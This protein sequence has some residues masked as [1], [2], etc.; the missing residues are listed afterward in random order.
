MSCDSGKDLPPYHL[1]HGSVIPSI[2]ADGKI[3]TTNG[4]NFSEDG[5]MLYTSKTIAKNS[6]S[7]TPFA[8]IFTSE[9]NDGIWRE[10]QQILFPI[11]A[12]HPVL[13]HDQKKLYFNSRSHPDTLD[14]FIKH[15][16]WVSERLDGNWSEP[17]LL[18]AVNSPYYDSYPSIAKSGN[19]YFNSDRPGGNGGM[20]IYVSKSEAGKLMQPINLSSINSKHV[21]NDLVV[22]PLERFIIFNRYIDSTRSI[23]LYVSFQEKDTWSTPVLLQHVNEDNQWELT[24][25]LSPEGSYFFYEVDNKIMQINLE[26]ILPN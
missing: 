1:E 3:T 7:G 21:E 25:S 18:N 26:M 20:D 11:D 5:N 22:D 13:S 14:K 9:Y 16:I 24:P 15:N 10:P 19:V 23:D 4:I 17:E 6:K 12:Y 2:F 8:A